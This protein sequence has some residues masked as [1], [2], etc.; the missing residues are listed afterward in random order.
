AKLIGTR[1]G[2]ISRIENVNYSKWST[3]TL[4]KL[5]RA[6]RVRL[7]VSFETYGSLLDEVETFSRPSLH[8][9]PRDLDPIFHPV[10]YPART[11]M[12]FWHSQHKDIK[13]VHVLSS[14]PKNAP[15][16]LQQTIFG[17]PKEFFSGF[18]F[19]QYQHNR[20]TSTLQES[21]MGAAR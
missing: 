21:V 16:Q 4:K 10:H 6:F 15:G 12:H 1:Q 9:T 11:F 18:Q 5:A 7:K 14:S 13:R 17:G 3:A 19:Q 8:R 20:P 2:V